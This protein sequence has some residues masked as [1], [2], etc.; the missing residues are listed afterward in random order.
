MTLPR[1]VLFGVLACGAVSTLR[2][3]TTFVLVD[4][5]HVVYGR[6]FDYYVAD[7]RVMVNRRGL[8]KTAFGTN[9]G[10]QWISR[11]GS[12]SFNQFGH[13]FPNGGMNEAGLVVEHML[14]DGTQ[15]PSDARPSLTELQWIQYQLDCSAT[16]ADVLASDAQVRIQPGSTGLHFL[17]ADRT[18][19]CAVIE[20][21]GGR[22]VCH[23]DGSLPVAA[24]TND[25]YDS[26]LAYE[27]V[28]SP[29]RADHVSSLG[30]FVQAAASVRSFPGLH[31]ADPIGYAF[32][33]L[34]NV[35]QPSGTPTQWSIVYDLANRIAY[36]RTRPVQS[37]KQIHLDA[38]DFRPGAPI[39]MMDINAPTGG[40]VTPQSIYSEEDNLA[41]LLS[42]YRQTPPLANTS[43]PSLER[44][45][46]YP[47]TVRAAVRPSISVHPVSATVAPGGDAMFGVTA[48]GDGTLTYQWRK[49]G[50][51][52]DGETNPALARSNLSSA[53]AGDYVVD[54]M[55]PV[56]TTTSR[57]ARLTVAV[58]EPG[59]LVNLSVRATAGTGGQPLIVGFVVRGG[60]KQVLVRAVGP[61]LA[62]LF[63]VP[64]VLVDPRLDVH[65]IIDGE[66]RI[67]A[68]NDNWGA[69]VTECDSLIAACALV[70]AFPLATTSRD[71]ALVV[72]VDGERTAQ[73]IAVPSGTSGV[74]LVEAYDAGAGNTPRLVN[75]STR[76][77][78][79][80]GND[81]LIAG[82]VIN[83]NVPMRLLVRGI[84]PSLASLFGVTG[85]LAD[86]RL[87][88]HAM[89][90]GHDT[91]VAAND[92]WPDEPGA[93]EAAAGVGAFALPSASSDAAV[94]VTLPAGAYTAVVAG[95]NGTTG[96]G[97]VEVYEIP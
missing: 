64:G 38:L 57:F 74:V 2:P 68:S 77:Q 66:D 79:G 15:Y 3:C 29:A 55:D 7:G 17:V 67:V 82:F 1:T 31:P 13:E 85:V 84:G 53:D 47:D 21:L 91:V 16:V 25:T 72:A 4:Q 20:F 37:I 11:Y 71:A 69:S 62:S 5:D 35:S 23:I 90:G 6:N 65:Q 50:A 33:A 12:L 14:L 30:R 56:G 27:A 24:L 26:S 34:A 61:G 87:E 42:V 28:T 46:A 75:L 93:A 81:V 97:L 22:L 95:V 45:A 63:S 96:N 70:G 59:R 60:A 32:S 73:V 43:T 40:E 8:L 58:P 9:S 51:P 49:D 76:S 89:V 83:G 54:V 10:L 78:V 52:L 48:T 80:S 86:P 92:N 39:R 36:F 94:V 18:G 19:R 44:R 41:V 88:L